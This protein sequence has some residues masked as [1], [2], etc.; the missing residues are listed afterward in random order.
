MKRKRTLESDAIDHTTNCVI[1]H[2]MTNSTAASS[3]IAA[4]ATAGWQHIEQQQQKC[5]TGIYK[6]I[7]TRIIRRTAAY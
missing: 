5:M 2:A 3:S 1:P 6:Y 7:H 4:A